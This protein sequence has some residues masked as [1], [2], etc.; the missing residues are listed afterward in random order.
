MINPYIPFEFDQ[1]CV[2]LRKCGIKIHHHKL[3]LIRTRRN[4]FFK[5]ETNYNYLHRTKSDSL[6][7]INRDNNFMH[8]KLKKIHKR[9]NKL[10]ET[11]EIVKNAMKE[12]KKTIDSVN[13]R[14]KENL[15]QSNNYFYKRLNSTKSMICPEKLNNDFILSRKIFTNLRRVKP[16]K[17]KKKITGLRK[18]SDIKI[19]KNNSMDKLPSLKLSL[20]KS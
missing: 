1:N 2:Y 13:K 14:I 12:K 5:K 8:E 10:I 20:N 9:K 6:F 11:N 17:E 4:P 19:N 18:N 15:I 7:F 16:I 3:D